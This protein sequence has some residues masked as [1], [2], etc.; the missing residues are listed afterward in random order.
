MANYSN[1]TVDKLLVEA[2][3]T[4]D[5]E[6]RITKYKKF[7]ELLNADSPVIFLYFPTYSYIQNK[8]IK[9]FDYI[10]ILNPSDRLNDASHWYI[11]VNREIEF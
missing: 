6:S 9:G 8:K 7:Q 5:K 3:E 2:R 11:K 1:S 4:T 10:N